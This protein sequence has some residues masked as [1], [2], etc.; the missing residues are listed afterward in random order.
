MYSGGQICVPLDQETR[1]GLMLPQ[2]CQLR[3]AL[4]SLLVTCQQQPPLLGTKQ[5]FTPRFW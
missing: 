1:Q 2:C 3:S 4:A 5:S